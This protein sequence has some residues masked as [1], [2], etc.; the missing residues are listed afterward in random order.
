[1]NL[2]NQIKM[3][4]ITGIGFDALFDN[5][6]MGII[7]TDQHGVIIMTNLFLQKQFG[8]T[9]VEMSG[10]RIEMLIPSRFRHKHV[11]HVEDYNEHPKNRPMGIGMD[12]FATRKDGT[13]FP[14]E[15]SLGSYETQHGRFVTAFVSDI[16]RRKAAEI[17]LYQLNEELEN[18][19]TERTQSLTE[20]VKQLAKLI[21]ET[22]AKDVEL[23]RVNTFLN[24]VWSHARAII[25]VTD[26]KGIIK[27][28]NA[29]AERQLGYH[30]SEIVEIANPALFTSQ[31]SLNALAQKIA[32][33]SNSEVAS[34]FDIL[35]LKADAGQHDENELLYIRKDG[36]VFPVSLTFTA[37]KN[38]LGNT[39]GYLGI[40]IDI[41]ERRKAEDDLRAALDKE[42]DLSELKSRF[43]S[44]ASHEFRTPL[45]TVLSSA[46]LISKYT[47]TDDNPKR[48]KHV[49]RIVSSVN[50]LTDILNDF[51]SVG[52]ME[53]GKIQVR[54]ST[55]NI[56]QAIGNVTTEINGLLKHGQKITYIHEGDP[57]VILDAALLKHIIMNLCSNAIKFSPESAEIS[58]RSKRT[59]QGLLLS[60]KDN[61]LGISEEDQEH[62]FERFFRG[63][64]VTNIQGT[65]LGLH[66]VSK[67]AELMNGNIF[68]KSILGAGTT[69]TI[70]F[71][72]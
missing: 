4:H 67:Y 37:M 14:V 18:K 1:M 36:T 17:A 3:N 50:M 32:S 12:L 25:F 31:L 40:A 51:L 56:K 72:F 2:A 30:S 66:L 65:G 45:S 15:V 5:V 58:I 22:E 26:E 39:E 71:R 24:S 55:F 54:L 43:V 7:I 70:D 13:E 27:M 52:K 62:L 20:S 34:G 21:T 9:A 68:C 69:F 10:Q 41:S 33:D 60:F 63:A 64:N 48:E 6:S 53:E 42:K 49:D 8:Y 29:A 38:N 61:G 16:S 46:Y 47:Q 57:D 11:E 28:F 19:V 35:K 23:T 44:M 59:D